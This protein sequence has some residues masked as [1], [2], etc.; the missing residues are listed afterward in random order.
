M[1]CVEWEEQVALHAGGDLAG[2]D[3]AA[4]E[5][6]LEECPG[7]QMLWSGMREDLAAL[8]S[9]HAELPGV[10]HFTAVR[11]RV[12]GQLERQSRPWWQRGWVYRFASL[13]AVLTVLAVWPRGPVPLAPR[14]L[15]S[16]PPAPLVARSAAPA[17]PVRPRLPSEPRRLVSA[18]REPV[19]VKL[20][21]ADPHIVI[22]W[23]A[24]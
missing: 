13:A 24:D 22:Y 20:Q 5:Q 10:A 18:G 11:S 15:A 19:T 23:I 14:M 1:N 21:T 6:H 12:L 2:A 4:V 3:G 17:A 8:K 16:I 7:C 9:A